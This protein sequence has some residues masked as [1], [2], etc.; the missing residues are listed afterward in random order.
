MPASFFFFLDETCQK[1]YTLY[2]SVGRHF[3]RHRLVACLPTHWKGVKDAI[4]YSRMRT[5][6]YQIREH[7]QNMRLGNLLDD[8]G[9]VH[10]HFLKLEKT[11]LPHLWQ[12]CRTLSPATA[13]DEVA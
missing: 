2:H 3:Q 13:L 9:D 6:K 7:P 12:V 8:L 11:I 4:R 1:C 5:Y 10:N